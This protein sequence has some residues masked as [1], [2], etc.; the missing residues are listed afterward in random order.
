MS[1][2]TSA[3]AAAIKA[4]LEQMRRTSQVIAMDIYFIALTLAI[5]I[6]VVR[7]LMIGSPQEIVS[8]ARKTVGPE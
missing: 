7:I 3:S 1:S 4:M 2:Q 6:P 8:R 5:V